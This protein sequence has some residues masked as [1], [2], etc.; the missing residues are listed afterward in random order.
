MKSIRS[1]AFA[2][3][4]FA[5]LVFAPA[6]LRADEAGAVFQVKVPDMSC[7]GCAISV[8]G[9]LKKLDHVTEVFVDP[10]T[11]VAIIAADNAEGPGEKAVLKAVKEAGYKG[12]A[13][14]KLKTSFAE[15]KA[16]LVSDKG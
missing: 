3:I 15:A 9:E 10:R 14:S 1:L 4:A 8:S 11:K 7:G 12:L 6:A 13:F 5:A 2:A 16:A